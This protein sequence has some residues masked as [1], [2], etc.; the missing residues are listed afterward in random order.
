MSLL[1]AALKESLE[2]SIQTRSNPETDRK[3]I[4]KRV[5][6]NEKR[7]KDES[8]VRAF[9][10]H[11]KIKLNNLMGGDSIV[12]KATEA[13]S[14]DEESL[15]SDCCSGGSS[16]INDD[17]DDDDYRIRSSL[18]G[19]RESVPSIKINGKYFGLY[20]LNQSRCNKQQ[21]TK[22]ALNDDL[23][24][25]GYRSLSRTSHQ[26]D[27][28]HQLQDIKSRL[29]DLVHELDFVART[30]LQQ[31]DVD[32]YIRRRDAL[33]AKVDSLIESSNRSEEEETGR[34]ECQYH[35]ASS[36]LIR[37]SITKSRRGESN[38]NYSSSDGY[39]EQVHVID[40][41][42]NR[43]RRSS[44]LNTSRSSNDSQDL[45]S[46]S[47]MICVTVGNS[48]FGYTDKQQP[49][50]F[51]PKK[52]RSVVEQQQQVG[53]MRTSNELP[54]GATTGGVS[55]TTQINRMT[56]HI[57]TNSS[58]SSCSHSSTSSFL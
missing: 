43:H 29:N 20:R 44:D 3:S 12:A 34:Y 25:D 9:I 55:T 6:L 31:E 41:N 30:H 38:L 21:V 54:I 36:S 16:T 57:A 10:S 51:S 45:P 13:T 5:D 26:A 19:N 2:W 37:K 27:L 42:L 50:G 23:C 7:L 24:D 48:H 17:D 15:E 1:E 4:N 14:D 53:Y 56:Q 52:E 47:N 39:E 22:S 18:N 33:I 11:F 40:Y 32:A 8:H 49:I 28:Q 58:A 46:T 35:S